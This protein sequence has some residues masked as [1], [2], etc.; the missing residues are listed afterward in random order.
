MRVTFH[1]GV[2]LCALSSTATAQ[3]VVG[4]VSPALTEYV[5]TLDPISIRSG[6]GGI[7]VAI[8][9]T[10]PTGVWWW[11]PG[12]SGC[13]TRNTMAQP[14]QE[15]VTGLAALFHPI[16]AVVSRTQAGDTEARFR[17]GLHGPPD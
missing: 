16:D 2:M 10:D 9:P 13:A 17:L 12:R 14:H 5:V 15:D 3:Q 8:D 1:I 4:A 6:P 7:C 11:G